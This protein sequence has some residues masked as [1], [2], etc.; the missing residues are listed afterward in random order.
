MALKEYENIIHRCF[1]C[2]YCKFTS[3]CS[4]LSFNCPV[5]NK[6]RL[7]T[8]SPGGMMWLIR[9]WMQKEI[10]WSESLAK[11]L[12]SCTTCNNCVE[13]CKFKFR[14]DIV[15]IIIA[16][17]QEMVENGLVLPKVKHFLESIEA[18]GNP[19]KELR[20]NRG[21]WAEGTR[22]KQ[23]KGDELNHFG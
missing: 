11:I 18:Y 23:Y 6:Y 4:Y 10:D 20:L 14:G 13:Q 16:A 22:I 12:Y 5:Y 1:R 15:N 21:R 3:D 9:A 2:G 8:Y 7:E 17:R 19:Y